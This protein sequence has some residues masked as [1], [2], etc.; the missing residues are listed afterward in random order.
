[1][2]SAMFLE[3][4]VSVA[5][6]RF[7][8]VT[9]GEPLRN[10][11]PKPKPEPKPAPGHYNSSHI[12]KVHDMQESLIDTNCRR[13]DTFGSYVTVS[14]RTVAVSSVN[15]SGGAGAVT[16]FSADANGEWTQPIRISSPV[17]YSSEFGST[18]SV[19]GEGNTLLVTGKVARKMDESDWSFVVMEDICVYVYSN[20]GEW[21][22]S[23]VLKLHSENQ[24]VDSPTSSAIFGD[25]FIVGAP[26]TVFES[27]RGVAYVFKLSETKRWL[28]H[29]ML[30]VS[31]MSV[32]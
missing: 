2:R 11:A 10:A 30:L 17:D 4:K 22:L 20:S 5:D 29:A 6:L 7:L 3:M 23:Q 27:F 24:G 8:Q 12:E 25:N 16:V 18:V 1:M 28:S 26:W 14:Q 13:Y 19:G 32:S 9:S 31:E 21:A 15:A